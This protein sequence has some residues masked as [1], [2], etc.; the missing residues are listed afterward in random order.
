MNKPLQF[1]NYKAEIKSCQRAI[2]RAFAKLKSGYTRTVKSNVQR[3][4]RNKEFDEADQ[5][6]SAAE[7]KL[8]ESGRVLNQLSRTIQKKREAE[9]R[10][11]A[12]LYQ[13]YQAAKI[14]YMVCWGDRQSDP[15]KF[16]GMQK[17]WRSLGAG[18]VNINYRCSGSL[19]TKM[20]CRKLAKYKAKYR[21]G[22]CYI[23]DN[24]LP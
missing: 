1:K 11:Q 17:C 6:I 8:G 20:C 2:G 10:R 24:S 22:E 23:G 13:L 14:N 12:R 15:Y 7:S 3:A 16:P 9:E 5:I 21:D 18:Y 4:L 19:A